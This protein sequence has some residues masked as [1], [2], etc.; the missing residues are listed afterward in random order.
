MVR[1]KKDNVK[2]EAK[3]SSSVLVV[4]KKSA[5][6][7]PLKSKSNAMK[8][9]SGNPAL[10]GEVYRELKEARKPQ[11]IQLNNVGPNKLWLVPTFL[12]LMIIGIA[13]IVI[14]YL[15]ASIGGYPL[16]VLG[17][18]NL[19]VGFLFIIVGFIFTTKWK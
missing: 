3:D 18:L 5:A 15:S 4:N 7:A 1:N 19:L 16:P 13:W 8:A 10:R 9:R 17:Y 11:K 14:F 12:G 6:K 2:V